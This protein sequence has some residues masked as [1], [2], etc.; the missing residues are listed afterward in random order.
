FFALSL[1]AFYLVMVLAPGAIGV[2]SGQVFYVWFSVFNLF[3]TMVF[4]AL[5]VD[6]FS[7]EQSKRFFGV[8]A[9]GGTC[10]AVFG[11][12]LASLLASPLGTPALLLVSIGFLLLAVGIAWLI[13]RLR[14]GPAQSPASDERERIGG[15]AWEG[16]RAVFHSPYLLGIAAYVV[17]LAVM[18]TFIYFTRLQMV[19]ALEGDLDSRTTLFARIDIVT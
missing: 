3:S 7:L 18:A 6:R 4:W 9:V 15:S 2:A 12:W 13:T 11:P 14:P 1:L 8:I 16:L 5:M 19:A 17:I 10:G